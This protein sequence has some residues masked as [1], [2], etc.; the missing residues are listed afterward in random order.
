MNRSLH[1][2]LL[3][4]GWPPES[5]TNGIVT[6]VHQLRRGLLAAGHRVSVLSC[7]PVQRAEPGVEGVRPDGW[8]E[9]ARRALAAAT[10]SPRAWDRSFADA[11]GDTVARLHDRDPLDCFEMEESFGWAADVAHRV[12]VPIVVR[13]H[14]PA[15]RTVLGPAAGAPETARRIAR[16]GSGLRAAT[17]VCAPS[18]TV[19]ADT[20]DRYGLAGKPGCAFGNPLAPIADADAW[21]PDPA[22]PPTV[23]FVGRFDHAKGADTLL[24]AF[25]LA[26]RR[27]PDLA[28]DF[29]GPD[30]G[31]PGRD[32]SIQGFE[33]AVAARMPGHDA[34]AIRFHG[35][36]PPDRISP[37]RAG[38][39]VVVV[40]S[41][42]ENQSYTAL[43]AMG[44]GCPLVSTSGG[45]HADLLEDGREGFLVPPG[46]PSA[47]AEAIL[48]VVDDP[49]GAAR[50]GRLARER[51]HRLHSPEAVASAASALYA[52][53]LAVESAGRAG[54]AA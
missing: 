42:W 49:V 50:L 45:G 12:P 34:A 23:L 27:R 22:R 17:A 11:L 53:C 54:V 43:E 32:G 26:R 31:L 21:K 5:Q 15:F 33:A 29:V 35:R 40:A 24:D 10:R 36:L 25:A 9:M 8:R 48:R 18:R 38:A 14:G 47:M 20:L 52:E 2:G 7:T 41:P 3:V 28:L 30:V 16:E 44:A 1:V 6:Y 13:L 37:L 39:S 46:D 51:A 4:P 19:L